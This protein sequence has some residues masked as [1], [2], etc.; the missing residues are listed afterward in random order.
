MESLPSR[1]V[2]AT[3]QYPPY[4]APNTPMEHLAEQPSQSKKDTLYPLYP[5]A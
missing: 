4:P 1:G 2:P 5:H 3:S